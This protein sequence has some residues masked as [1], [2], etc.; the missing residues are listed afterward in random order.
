[1]TMGT[2]CAADPG[3]VYP[4]RFEMTGCALPPR[5]GL[6]EG[7]QISNFYGCYSSAE[8]RCVPPRFKRCARNEEERTNGGLELR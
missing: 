7:R 1:M 8:R 2:M 6:I 3:C 5:S 4:I